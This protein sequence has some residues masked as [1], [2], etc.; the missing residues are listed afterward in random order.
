MGISLNLDA[1]NKN[2]FKK[3]CHFSDLDCVHCNKLDLN[4]FIGMNIA[5]KTDDFFLFHKQT[6]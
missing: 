4:L 3:L 5:I 6:V 2:Y 1:T